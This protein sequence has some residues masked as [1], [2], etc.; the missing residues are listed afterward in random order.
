MHAQCLTLCDPP[1]SSVHGILQVRIL[2]WV[3][4][5][6]SK[7][8]SQPRS[9]TQVSCVSYIGK[10][11]LYHCATWEAPYGLFKLNYFHKGPIFKDSYIGV[12][13][14]TYEFKRRPQFSASKVPK[15]PGK[16]ISFEFLKNYFFFWLCWVFIAACGLSPVGESK[17]YS[18]WRCSAIWLWWLL[19]SWSMGSKVCGLQ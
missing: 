14:L 13:A 5:S 17:V 2:E 7:G 11:I 12:L 15:T 19:L 9:R 16:G 4:I 18:G 6:S 8:S 3:A 10:W 1:G